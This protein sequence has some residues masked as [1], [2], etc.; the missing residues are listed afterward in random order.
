M[1]QN[2]EGSPE[3]SNFPTWLLLRFALRREH[4]PDEE[5]PFP[6]LY[7]EEELTAVE[8]WCPR[9]TSTNK[10]PSTGGNNES[11]GPKCLCIE[12]D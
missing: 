7:T 6:F 1:V 12:C 11:R 3:T 2:E 8:L 10:A 4:G 5:L 9:T